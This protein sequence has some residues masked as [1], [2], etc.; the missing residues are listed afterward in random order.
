MWCVQSSSLISALSYLLIS[1]IRLT[2]YWVLV[3]AEWSHVFI[4]DVQL[5]VSSDK[6]SV[7]NQQDNGDTEQ[8]A[9]SHLPLTL[10]SGRKHRPDWRSESRPED[11]DI[12]IDL[13]RI[14]VRRH[15]VHRAETNPEDVSSASEKTSAGA[16]M[17][18]CLTTS[19]RSPLKC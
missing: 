8:T 5:R 17:E 3:S 14:T 4:S 13:C 6:H 2:G 15:L 12:C 16:R 9:A 11:E 7:I 10:L 18:V 1:R 19:Q